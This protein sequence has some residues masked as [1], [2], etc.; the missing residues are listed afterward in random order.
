M[1]EAAERGARRKTKDNA[2]AAGVTMSD[3]DPGQMREED[4]GCACAA[5]LKSPSLPA[6]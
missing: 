4:C 2:T 1:E 6:F 5:P 3:D